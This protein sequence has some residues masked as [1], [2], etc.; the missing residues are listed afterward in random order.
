MNVTIYS[1]VT[2]PY[3]SMLKKYF[4]EKNVAF[5]EKLVDQDDTARIEMTKLSDGF[6]GVPYT[7]IAKDGGT[8]EKIIGFDKAKIDSILG[9]V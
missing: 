2:C 4:T 3:C 9:L 6:L 7:V 5:I 8:V 1:T